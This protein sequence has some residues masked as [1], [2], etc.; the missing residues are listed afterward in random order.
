MRLKQLYPFCHLAQKC[1]HQ[2]RICLNK[3]FTNNM[4]GLNIDADSLIPGQ[5][6]VVTFY[7]NYHKK[8]VTL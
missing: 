5:R 4:E 3:I 7:S 8:N 2:H 6:Y 1:L